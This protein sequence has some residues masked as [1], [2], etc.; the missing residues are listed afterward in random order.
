[1]KK[2]SITIIA[3]M[4]LFS[5]CYT[6]DRGRHHN[7]EEKISS[8]VYEIPETGHTRNKVIIVYIDPETGVNY[9]LFEDDSYP[10]GMTVRLN[11]DGTPMVTPLK[12]Q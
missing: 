7:S 1:M 10:G 9:L 4:L 12:N 5:A 6:P 2:I 11:P 3:S 8:Q